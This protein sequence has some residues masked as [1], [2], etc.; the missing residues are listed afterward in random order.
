MKHVD[1]EN[2][3]KREVVQIQVQRMDEI[4]VLDL[5]LKRYHVIHKHVQPAQVLHQVE[6]LLL[7]RCVGI[8]VLLIDVLKMM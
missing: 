3:L 4:A 5:L 8:G 6:V 1:E 2:K 7:V